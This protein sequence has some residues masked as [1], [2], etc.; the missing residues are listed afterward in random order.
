MKLIWVFLSCCLLLPT[1]ARAAPVILVLGD[2]LSAGYGLAEHQAWPDLLQQKLGSNPS[3]RSWHVVNASISGETS[4]GGWA[5]LPSALAQF[6]PIIVIIELGA[7]DGLRGLSLA[8]LQS[9]LNSM[10]QQAR[11]VSKH[12]I[13]IGIHLPTN[14]GPSY[15]QALDQVYTSAATKNHITLI[16]SLLEGVELHPELFQPDGLHPVAAAEPIIMRH[17]WQ[18]L[19]PMLHESYAKK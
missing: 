10:L 9:N 1:M 4:A 12:V 8:A 14:Y 3:T 17:V 5:R 7:N 18:S 19:A 6:Y 15:N 2:S 11:H 16:P 13:L